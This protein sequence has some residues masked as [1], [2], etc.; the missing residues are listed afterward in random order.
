ML[1]T[2]SIYVDCC[3]TAISDYHFT[4]VLMVR[5]TFELEKDGERGKRERERKRKR[6]RERYR[7]RNLKNSIF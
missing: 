5:A 7:I 2:R 6:E 3:G 1:I 4:T